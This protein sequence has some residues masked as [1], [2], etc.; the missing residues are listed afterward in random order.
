MGWQMHLKLI[1]P[2]NGNEAPSAHRSG[3]YKNDLVPP[4]RIERTTRGLG[5]RCDSS[6]ARY[7]GTQEQGEAEP[8][9]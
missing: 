9:S 7:D 4:I 5:K 6:T 8:T 1:H 2:E 3:W